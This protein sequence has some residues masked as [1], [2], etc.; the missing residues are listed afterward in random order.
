MMALRLRRARR[1]GD[2]WFGKHPP[3]RQL[4][5]GER[6]YADWQWR[7]T[8]RD[9]GCVWRRAVASRAVGGTWRDLPV[10]WTVVAVLTPAQR[11]W[12]DEGADPET[13]LTEVVEEQ[14]CPAPKPA[15]PAWP[16]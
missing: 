10:H 5:W 8:L 6:A 2:D 15:W 3:G 12:L 1:A 13:V 4:A 9:D 14:R 16:C 7:W 11:K